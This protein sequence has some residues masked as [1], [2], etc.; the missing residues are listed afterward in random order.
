LPADAEGK[1]G[2]P[3]ADGQMRAPWILSAGSPASPANQ[4]HRRTSPTQA[5][6]R[7]GRFTSEGWPSRASTTREWNFENATQ[8]QRIQPNL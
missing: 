7:R 6:V 5:S 3:L 8:I 4:R 2:K 1:A